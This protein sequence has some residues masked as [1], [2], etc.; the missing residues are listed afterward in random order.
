MYKINELPGYIE[1]GN[2]NEK[3]VCE[4]A[5]DVSAWVALYP[6]GTFSITYMRPG[7]TDVYPVAAGDIVVADGILIWT[8]LDAVTATAG[9]GSMVI[10]CA[11]GDTIVKKSPLIQTVIG[12]GHAASGDPPEPL[13]DYVQKWGAVD[14]TIELLAPGSEP[15]I[16]ITQDENGT[17]FPFKI[18]S[19]NVLYA[20]FDIDTD[21]GDLIM[22]TPENY[23]GPLF[24]LNEETG[25]LEV[26]IN[27]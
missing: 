14:G 17:H 10:Q 3:G 27:G 13:A 26:I 2:L 7:E 16:N 20:T 11:V 23:D 12:A 8:V 6:T 9:S 1:L 21:T 22:T 18:P 4:I 5:V 25:N 15:E 19:G 24:E